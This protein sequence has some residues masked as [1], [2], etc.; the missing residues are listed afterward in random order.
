MSLTQTLRVTLDDGSQHTVVVDGRDLRAWEAWRET[1]IFGTSSSLTR[2][3]E[4]AYLSGRRNG[5]W[6]GTYEEWEPR[7][8][9][10]DVITSDVAHPSQKAPSGSQSSPS[11]SE[12]ESAPSSGKSRGKKQF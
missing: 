2:L 10:V 7:A 4:W 12:Q 11:P 8:V 3:A 5:L 1:S 6:N 9:D